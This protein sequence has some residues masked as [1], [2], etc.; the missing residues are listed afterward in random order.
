VPDLEEVV[1]KPKY[2]KQITAKESNKNIQLE[3]ELQNV[4][5]QSLN[6]V[7]KKNRGKQFEHITERVDKVEKAVKLMKI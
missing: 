6:K 3:K 7:S 5:K 2:E 4:F 1:L